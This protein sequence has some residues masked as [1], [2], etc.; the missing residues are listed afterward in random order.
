MQEHFCL[1]NGVNNVD[2]HNVFHIA[3]RRVF[4]DAFSD[5]QVKVVTIYYTKVLKQPMKNK[6]VQDIHL[7]EDQYLQS[8][9]DWLIKDNEAWKWLCR[10]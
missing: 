9:V 2:A 6:I 5:V 7:T 1:D 10:Y 4:K 8:C 3:V